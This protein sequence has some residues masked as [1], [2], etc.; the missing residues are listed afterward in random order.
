MPCQ[1]CLAPNRTLAYAG[2]WHDGTHIIPT[3]DSDDGDAHS[4]TASSSAAHATQTGQQDDDDDKD[5]DSDEDTDSA[6]KGNRRRQLVTSGGK[7]Q[8]SEGD[9]FFVPKLDSDDAGFV[10]TPVLAQFNFTGESCFSPS[11]PP[12][13]FILLRYTPN[14]TEEGGFSLSIQSKAMIMWTNRLFLVDLSGSAIYVFALVPLLA[15]ASNNT[16]TF[17]NLTA[18]L[19]SQ[20]A[21]T[22]LHTGSPLDSSMSNI[23][24]YEKSQ[25]IFMKTGLSEGPH[26]LM[27]N[28]GPDSVLLL[29]YIVYSQED[30]TEADTDNTGGTASTTSS[31][32]L[33]TRP[34][35]TNT[36]MPSAALSQCV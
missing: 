9:P 24:S 12:G 22:F 10:D 11:E 8:D 26:T 6:K 29:D 35:S 32:Q 17:V 3:V 1:T 21:G 28:V 5:D 2:T 13:P 19:D 7:R 18:T 16:P 4:A 33:S 30:V 34:A 36:P 15:A 23:T 25:P 14:F 31:V 20:V 27:L